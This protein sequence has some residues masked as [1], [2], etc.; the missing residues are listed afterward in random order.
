MAAHICWLS[1]NIAPIYYCAFFYRFWRIF[2][3]LFVICLMNSFVGNS[4]VT[5]CVYVALIIVDQWCCQCL[6]ASWLFWRL[7]VIVVVV[8]AHE[9]NGI[10]VSDW[11][12]LWMS[13]WF[14]SVEL[15]KYEYLNENFGRRHKRSMCA[16]GYVAS[17]AQTNNL[18]K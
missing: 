13:K 11:A 9:A 18:P 7:L 3:Q 14:V 16:Y 5:V 2:T 8:N 6:R 15:L 12:S 17:E 1:V 10:W 4:W